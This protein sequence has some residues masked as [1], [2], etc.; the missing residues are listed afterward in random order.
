MKIKKII[1]ILLGVIV[2]IT[3]PTLLFFTVL[4]VKYN[5]PLPEAIHSV[6]ADVLAQKMLKALNFKAYKTTNVIEWTFKKRHHFKWY[7][8]KNICEVFWKKYKVYLDFNNSNNSK[9]FIKDQEVFKDKETLIQKA[10]SY[11]YNDSFWLVAPYKVFDE[12][13]SRKLVTFKDNTKGL[14]VHYSKGGDTPGDTYLWLFDASG[15]PKSFK[16]WTAILPIGGLEA[17]WSDWTTT[18]TGAVLPH[19]HKLLF[20]GLEIDGIKTH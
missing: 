19:F 10:T 4:Y 6:E 18:S 13:T 3:L 7:K 15:K 14:L 1:K 8:N 12:G 20:L 9:V 5:E 2:F 11:F 17:S 16:M